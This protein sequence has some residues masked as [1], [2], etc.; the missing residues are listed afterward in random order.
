MN[1][2]GACKYLRT[3]GADK[4]KYI[5]ALQI[6]VLVLL[7]LMAMDCRN[8]IFYF[9][10]AAVGLTLLI[11]FE[12]F[13]IPRAVIPA[14]ILTASIMLFSPNP[15]GNIT[16]LLR[17]IVYPMCF[18]TGYNLCESESAE[19]SGRIVALVI[20]AVAAG[21]YG[22][23]L[24]NMLINIGKS[25]SR[26]TLDIWTRSKVSATGQSTMAIMMTGV[27]M[28]VLFSKFKPVWKIAALGI[29][30]S[31]MYYNLMLGGRT[32]FILA[33]LS[34]GINMIVSWCSMK[35]TNDRIR[36][37]VII[38]F[39]L[40]AMV[41]VLYFNL[42]GIRN[43]I[44]NSEFYRRF[45]GKN[46]VESLSEDGRLEHKLVYIRYMLS[47]PFGG[48]KLLKVVGT[49]AHDIFLDTYSDAGIFALLA[50]A[51]MIV[52]TIIKTVKTTTSKLIGRRTKILILNVVCLTLAVFM[53]EPI[54]QG[55]PWLFASFCAISGSITKLAE[56]TTPPDIRKSR[57]LRN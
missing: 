1:Q 46:S 10:V 42:F 9:A 47:Y 40:M 23:Y 51:A 16:V 15:T 52:S 21:A 8:K 5:Q 12:G 22:H 4:T 44:Y 54:L 38:A 6:V 25:V 53:L 48:A 13:D 27:T 39:V 55:M 32:I 18:L 2:T 41:I 24:L 33:A 49:Y 11:K 17:P 31:I 35:D 26:N 19:K 7:S 45:F 30:A 43:M 50:V 14:L 34:L 56:F 29:L 57:L 28:A 20:L 36:G 3:A 37:L